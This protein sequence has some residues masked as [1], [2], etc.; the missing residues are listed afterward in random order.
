M[1]LDRAAR[2]GAARDG[3]ARD[4]ATRRRWLQDCGRR[5]QWE[6]LRAQGQRR[7]GQWYLLG[8]RRQRLQQRVALRGRREPERAIVEVGALWG[9]AGAL[10]RGN[11]LQRDVRRCG[12]RLAR[13]ARCGERLARDARCGER[14]VTLNRR[15]RFTFHVDAVRGSIPDLRRYA[16]PRRG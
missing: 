4:G 14:L 1:H 2:D 16:S 9:K 8:T 11:R 5:R 12:E 6:L 3:A 15:I 13:D 7:P 10:R